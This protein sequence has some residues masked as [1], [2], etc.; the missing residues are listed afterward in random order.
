MLNG[1]KYTPVEV[2]VWIR[3]YKVGNMWTTVQMSPRAQL[4][5]W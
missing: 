5:N 4:A 3:E 1:Q 2:F